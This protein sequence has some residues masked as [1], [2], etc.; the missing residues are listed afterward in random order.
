MT[1][2]YNLIINLIYCKKMGKRK[3][4]QVV[5]TAAAPRILKTFDCPFCSHLETVEVKME[6]PK[7]KGTL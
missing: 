4:R 1:S 2:N 7:S 5:K 3:S 6:R